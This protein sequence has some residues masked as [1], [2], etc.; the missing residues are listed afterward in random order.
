MSTQSTTGAN[1]RP[2]NVE[3]V[4][5]WAGSGLGLIGAFILALNLPISG[6]GFVAFLV[7]NLFWIT[8]AFRKR[9][10]GLLTMQAGFTLTSVLGI[11]RWIA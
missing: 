8:W 2:G 5:E 11:A 6:Y 9:A 3:D 7:S 1:L 10:Y 4:I